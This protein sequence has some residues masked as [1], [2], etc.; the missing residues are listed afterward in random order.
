MAS[1]NCPRESPRGSPRESTIKLV[2]GEGALWLL[3]IV[4][5]AHQGSQ[6]AANQQTDNKSSSP[7]PSNL[8]DKQNIFSNL[9]TTSFRE[10]FLQSSREEKGDSIDGILAVLRR[11]QSREGEKEGDGKE[12]G[13]IDRRGGERE[14]GEK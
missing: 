3:R 7:Q 4:Q 1:L 9:I 8:L 12:R 10:K 6:S 5:G 13:L 2:G 11:E 14:K